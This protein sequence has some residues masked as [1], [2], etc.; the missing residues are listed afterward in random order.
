MCPEMSDVPYGT[1]NVKWLQNV[2]DEFKE[3]VHYD[4]ESSYLFDE[5]I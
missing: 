2:E 3:R 5:Q 4:K 1:K